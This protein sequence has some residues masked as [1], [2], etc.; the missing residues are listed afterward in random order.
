MKTRESTTCMA[1]SRVD[2][3]ALNSPY[4]EVLLVPHPPHYS[5]RAL[6]PKTTPS[7]PFKYTDIRIF[8]TFG[9]CFLLDFKGLES[10]LQITSAVL[11]APVFSIAVG[12]ITAAGKKCQH[13]FANVPG[14]LLLAVRVRFP[15]FEN[16]ELKK[17]LDHFFRC[18][19]AFPGSMINTFPD[20]GLRL[21]L[22]LDCFY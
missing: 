12:R 8:L 19:I 1:G 15:F 11:P 10:A 13:I 5:G 18:Q 2:S 21:S 4:I 17:L 6:L 9:I 3:G 7:P 16:G 22:K 20:E 14:D